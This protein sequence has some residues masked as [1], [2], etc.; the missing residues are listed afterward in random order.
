MHFKHPRVFAVNRIASLTFRDKTTTTKPILYFDLILMSTLTWVTEKVLE[1]DKKQRR[2]ISLEKKHKNFKKRE[3][4]ATTK[5][6]MSGSENKRQ[7]EHIKHVTRK[8]LELSC[9]SRAKQRQRNV[10]LRKCATRAK[11]FFFFC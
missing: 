1:R 5:V 2:P 11:V 9:C 4:L 10:Q 7:Q 3:M 8:F 6:K